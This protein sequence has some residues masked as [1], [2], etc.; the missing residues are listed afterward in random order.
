[1]LLWQHTAAAWHPQHYMVQSRAWSVSSAGALVGNPTSESATQVKWKLTWV[2]HQCIIDSLH[3]IFRV[4]SLFL[5]WLSNAFVACLEK[6]NTYSL[7]SFTGSGIGNIVSGEMIE[8]IGYQ[9]SYAIFSGCSLIVLVLYFLY[10]T[11]VKCLCKGET[12]EQ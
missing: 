6:L 12:K 7:L 5:E 9:R 8:Q 2:S 10:N 3:A 1:M 11:A 4:A